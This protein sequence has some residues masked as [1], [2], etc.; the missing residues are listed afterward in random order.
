MGI[1]IS[2]ISSEIFDDLTLSALKTVFRIAQNNNVM[3]V[4][5]NESTNFVLI[6]LN[7]NFL[8]SNVLVRFHIHRLQHC[9]HGQ[10]KKFISTW[11]PSTQKKREAGK[12]NKR[13]LSLDEKIKILD[14]VKKRK[15][16][17]R[18]IAKSL[19]SKDVVKNE[20]KLSD[21]FENL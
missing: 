17:C 2:Y 11:R 14:E 7:S 12:F 10:T 16:S 20:V 15:L 19:K 6:F 1:S 4:I 13:C 3:N 18:A 21:E 5:P 8:N 9:L